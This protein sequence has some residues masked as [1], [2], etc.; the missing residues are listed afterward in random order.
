[1][2]VVDYPQQGTIGANLL[3]K[4]YDITIYQGDTFNV[5]F[6]FKNNGVGVDLGAGWSG[7]C[8]FRAAPGG[9]VVA[10][11]TVTLNADGTLGKVRLYLQTDSLTPA[12]Y[13][14]DFE[15]TD[16]SGNKRT[17]FGGKVTIDQDVSE[18]TA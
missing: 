6:N 16:P 1:M 17:Y 11:P 4:R 5:V 8:Q 7:L 18:P 12:E 3:P 9:A 13:Q 15:L 2:G 14:W 10:S